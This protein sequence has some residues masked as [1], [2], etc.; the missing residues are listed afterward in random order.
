M[1]ILPTPPPVPPTDPT[2]FPLLWAFASI[3]AAIVDLAPLF[4]GEGLMLFRALAALTIAWFGIQTAL[5]G[6]GVPWT[7]FLPMVLAMSFSLAMLRFY[8]A[9]FPGLGIPVSTLP[10]RAADFYSRSID[11]FISW[12]FA[13]SFHDGWQEMTSWSLFDFLSGAG[14]LVWTFVILLFNTACAALL[15]A[16]IAA[17]RV[18]AGACAVLG[19][20]F[21]PWLFVPRMDFLFWGWL[22]SYL[23]FS[24]YTAVGWTFLALCTFMLDGVWRAVPPGLSSKISWF[25]YSATVLLVAVMAMFKVHSLTHSIFHGGGSFTSGASA[26]A[27]RAARRIGL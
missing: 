3:D 11:G 8:V 24:F 22:R 2:E 26:V 12:N 23:Q 19:P 7:R 17:G 13:Q 25:F 16:A 15:I 10:M 27:A 14:S 20:L 6:Q 1:Q 21:I 9:D 5:S 18:A 4:V